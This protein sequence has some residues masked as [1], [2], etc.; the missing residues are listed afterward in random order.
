M[1]QGL[2]ERAKSVMVMW[3]WLT[4]GGRTYQRCSL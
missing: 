3:K 2:S 1:A 4:T